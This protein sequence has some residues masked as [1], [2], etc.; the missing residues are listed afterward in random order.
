MIT[1]AR[2]FCGCGLPSTLQPAIRLSKLHRKPS[3]RLCSLGQTGAQTVNLLTQEGC[4]VFQYA[5]TFLVM[6]QEFRT[7]R[8]HAGLIAGERP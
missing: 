5:K 3:Q 1:T 7:C 4:G 6:N 2:S 8:L